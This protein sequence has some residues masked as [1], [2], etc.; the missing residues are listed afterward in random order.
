MGFWNRQKKILI[1]FGAFLTFMFVCTL[2]SRAVYASK[3]PQVTV[4]TPRR[5][6]L[7][8]TVKAEGIV[9]PGREYAVTALAG[10]RVRTVYANVGDHV[11][12]ETL[13]FDLDME[14]LKQKIQE[15]ELEIKMCQ[16][17]IASME[18]NRSLDTQRQK[19]ENERALEDYARA[20]A[21]SGE[22]LARAREDLEDAEDAYD[23]HKDHG[24]QTTPE[25]ERKAQ[26]EAYEEWVNKGT[27]LQK[28]L[29]DAKKRYDDALEEVKRLEASGVSPNPELPEVP[30]SESSEDAGEGEEGDSEE[31]QEAAEE[32]A[33][34]EARRVAEEIGRAH[35]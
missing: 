20:D 32:Q 14:D 29:E 30:S 16:L 6:A 2:V 22:S 3:L 1:G 9:H 25:E 31:K 8:H 27:E 28:I 7:D 11:M 12:P 26:Q 24:V 21:Q 5:M 4:D 34:Q 13:L 17:Q 19:T 15:K 18:Q 10:L 35:V 33:L 23:D